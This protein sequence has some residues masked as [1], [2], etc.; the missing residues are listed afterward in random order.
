[1]VRPIF[2]KSIY[3]LI[4]SGGENFIVLGKMFLGNWFSIISGWIPK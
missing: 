2:L 4:G 3:L 1:M